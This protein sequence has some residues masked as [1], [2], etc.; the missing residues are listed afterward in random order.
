MVNGEKGDPRKQDFVRGACHNLE[1]RLVKWRDLST[2]ARRAQSWPRW[3]RSQRGVGSM[4]E[5]CAMRATTLWAAPRTAAKTSDTV[6]WLGERVLLGFLPRNR[7]SVRP[8]G[9]SVLPW[10][11]TLEM[12]GAKLHRASPAV[13][14][15]PT[16]ERRLVPRDARDDKDRSHD[17]ST[18]ECSRLKLI[19]RY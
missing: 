1:L 19:D 6:P 10:T 16:T 8:M 3:A 9:A 12:R 17:H 14:V 2:R 5:R 11:L 15:L 4:S 13:L 7:S 18:F